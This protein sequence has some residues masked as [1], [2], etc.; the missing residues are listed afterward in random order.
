M[1]GQP[2]NEEW[3]GRIGRY[4]SRRKKARRGE[5]YNSTGRITGKKISM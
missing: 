3:L 1:L 5:K 2:T 4:K